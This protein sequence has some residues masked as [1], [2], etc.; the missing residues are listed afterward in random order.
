MSDEEKRA[1]KPSITFQPIKTAAAE[2][3]FETLRKTIVGFGQLKK[4]WDTYDAGPPSNEAI[5]MALRVLNELEQMDELEV[6]I[7]WA[8][9]TGDQSILFQ[10]MIG[11][12]IYHWQFDSDGDIAV[13]E[14]P[15]EGEPAYLD[16]DPSEIAEVLQGFTHAAD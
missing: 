1:A 14:K 2:D 16:V 7:E 9:P 8:V 6:S 10:Y 12:T 15:A 13:M 3:P 4:G 5:T 11:D